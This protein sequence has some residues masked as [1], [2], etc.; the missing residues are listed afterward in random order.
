MNC[1]FFVAFVEC[2]AIALVDAAKGAMIGLREY[3]LQFLVYLGAT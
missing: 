2:L 1:E 3:N